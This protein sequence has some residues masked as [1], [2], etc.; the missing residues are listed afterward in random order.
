MRAL[1]LASSLFAHAVAGGADVA[2]LGEADLGLGGHL[3]R[4]L[5][6]PGALEQARLLCAF[7]FAR[8]GLDADAGTCAQLPR[9][10]VA[11][12]R[13]DALPAGSLVRFRGMVRACGGRAQP[14]PVAHGGCCGAGA[15]H[16]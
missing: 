7:R 12:A 10:D 15:R 2:T 3:E 13:L 9:A 16:V 1:E 8:S 14:L 6:T 11:G 4:E 5:S